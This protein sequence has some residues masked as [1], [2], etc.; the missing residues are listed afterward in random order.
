MASYAGFAKTLFAF[1]SGSATHGTMDR[2]NGLRREIGRR[3]VLS[4][5]AN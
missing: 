4:R 1:P 3:L 5:P 2:D